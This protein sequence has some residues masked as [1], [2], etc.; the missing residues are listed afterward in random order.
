MRVS[1][2]AGA[3]VVATLAFAGNAFAAPIITTFNFVPLGSLSADT[4][5]VTTATTITDG[6]PL[7]VGA[8]LTDNTGLLSAQSLSLT[9]PTPV[10]LGAT[11]QKTFTTALGDFTELL[12]VT[13][14]QKGTSSL[15][16]AATG[17]I[18]E[19]TV[20]SG[21]A[22]DSAPVYYSASYTQN[23]GPGSQINGSF[24]DSTTPPPPP[25]VPEPASMALLGTG[26]IGLAGFGR[27]R[28]A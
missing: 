3:A 18:T 23:A 25:S 19:T 4:G 27:R 10:T 26:L 17:T 9:S 24:N 8:I 28:R 15:G 7:V 6:S 2:F 11:F 20:L 21:V 13:S 5:N 16:I 1:K 22:L 14:V 12:T